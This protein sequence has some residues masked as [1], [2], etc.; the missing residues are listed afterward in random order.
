MI[1]A[2]DE[3]GL[4]KSHDG[5]LVLPSD[6]RIGTLAKEYFNV[7]EDYILDVDITPN[8]ADALSHFGV[9][10]DLSAYYKFKE[11]NIAPQFPLINNLEK[12]SEFTFSNK[13]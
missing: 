1:C 5:I 8:R 10:R 6:V 7:E 13:Y 12:K 9:A 2:E 4:G 3:I 11:R